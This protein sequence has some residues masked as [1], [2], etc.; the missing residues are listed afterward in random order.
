MRLGFIIHGM[1]FFKSL[2]PLIEEAVHQGY[3]PFIFYFTG[4][5]A[6]KYDVAQ[7]K[8]FPKS[9]AAIKRAPFNNYSSLP[10]LM[11]GR[12]IDWVVGITLHQKT[13]DINKEFSKLGIK[14]CSIMNFT[15]AFWVN[16]ITKEDI[17]N[18]DLV[19]YQSKYSLNFHKTYL[20]AGKLTRCI[21]SGLPILDS[22]KRLPKQNAIMKR[23][24]LPKDFLLIM[25]PNLRKGEIPMGFGS[26][27]K[28]S[29][30]IKSICKIAKSN[31][32]KVVGKSRRKQWHP[33]DLE[34]GFEKIIYD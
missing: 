23:Y 17:K 32:I 24:G 15:D 8:D 6:K 18:V 13:R 2:G 21:N 7:P 11:R 20:H 5:Y 9:M 34:S 31:G 14:K 26:I 3:V 22:R 28:F 27:D 19:C 30:L 10:K 16:K 12:A 29:K 33:K 25:L 4:N 1:T